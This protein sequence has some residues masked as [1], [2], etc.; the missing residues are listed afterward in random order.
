MLLEAIAFLITIILILFLLA[1]SIIQ[2]RVVHPL[3]KVAFAS[4]QVSQ[5][6]LP[7]FTQEINLVAE[8]DLNRE[9]S[10]NAELLNMKGN[11]EVSTVSQAHDE[12]ILS[13]KSVSHAFKTMTTNIRSFV[14]ELNR[15]ANELS[16]AK[17]EAESANKAKSEFLANM[18]HEIRTPLNGV[19][20]L[21]PI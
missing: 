21:A 5:K 12:I 1:Y 20:G 7:I 10:M 6:T 16:I 8:G 2:N 19:L 13:L 4:Y 11:D 17:E 3:Q 18:S 14:E 15:Q 9:V